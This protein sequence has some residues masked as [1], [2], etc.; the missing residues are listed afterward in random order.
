VIVLGTE[1]DADRLALA[2]ELGAD[3]VLAAPTD[4]VGAV[5]ELTGGQA[6]TWW[7]TW[8]PGAV[9]TVVDAIGMAGTRGQSLLAASKHGHPVQGFP[10]DQVVRKEIL[11]RRGYADHATG[12]LEPAMPR[13]SARAVSVW[14]D[15]HHRFSLERAGRCVAHRRPGRRIRAIHVSVVPR[16]PVSRSNN[17]D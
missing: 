8:R 7:W 12:R 10:H 5:L 13:S 17:N 9:S 15:V 3:H 2:T 1:R 6:P 4:P 14:P 11:L 16:P